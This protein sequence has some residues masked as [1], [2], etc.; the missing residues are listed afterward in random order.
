MNKNELISHVEAFK[1]GD[2]DKFEAI[3]LETNSRLYNYIF[4]ISDSLNNDDCIELVQ[5][6]FIQVNNKIET[7]K[8][9]RAFYSW[10]FTIAR[11]KS[12]RYL[13]KRKNEVLLSEEG[14]GL[15]EQ[16]HETDEELLPQDILESKEK[17]KM[18]MDILN[19]LPEEQKEVIYLRY[20]NG[21]SVKQIAEKLD[22]PDGTVKSRLNYGRKKIQT[23]VEALE[24]KGTKLYGFTGLP[25]ILLLLRNALNKGGIPV[26]QQQSILSN[27]TNST[28]S[29]GLS[30]SELPGNTANTGGR[31]I[32]TAT[33]ESIKNASKALSMKAI[34]AIIASAML[35]G[36]GILV[37][38]KSTVDKVANP[39]ITVDN[40]EVEVISRDK[41]EVIDTERDY[42]RGEINDFNTDC[43][44]LYEVIR[45]QNYFRNDD[46]NDNWNINYI[47]SEIKIVKVEGGEDYYD[48][49]QIMWA[50][51]WIDIFKNDVK[52]VI[53]EKE[54]VA[55]LTDFTDEE[56]KSI[57]EA[58]EM[59]E[60]FV[61]NQDIVNSLNNKIG[62][63]EACGEGQ[64]GYNQRAQEYAIKWN[65]KFDEY[66]ELLEMLN[67]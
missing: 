10:M 13:E 66:K 22:I 37:Y 62:E 34:A 18:V 50:R 26:T 59:L 20:Y 21:L 7:L 64:Y 40:Q 8:E 16:Q 24:K 57:S 63:V 32:K 54:L 23:E 47:I 58:N 31:G 30:G 55:G 6:T 15:F 5:E 45:T 9:G 12:L 11:N 56:K 49:T 19:S 1:N 41:E 53:E 39:A 61:N 65:E 36:I 4:S 46:K 42:V 28:N 52:N 2:K 43:K 67:K 35:I 44:D 38:N 17:Q 33:E 51:D 3:Y 48:S 60:Y 27:I 25:I 29:T 14:Q